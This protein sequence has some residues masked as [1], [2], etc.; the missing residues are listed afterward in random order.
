[1]QTFKKAERLTSKKTI[2]ELMKKG[3]SFHESPF[4]VI[5]L[6]IKLDTAFPAQIV[7]SIPKRNFKKAVT[8]NK[9]KR[10]TREA[11]RKNKSLLYEALQKNKAQLAVMLVYTAKTEIEYGEIESK[12]IVALRRLVE[13]GSVD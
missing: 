3:R 8:R 5:Y 4:K 1:M 10:R 11:Y 9:L 7:I 13:N 2:E 12:I 6:E